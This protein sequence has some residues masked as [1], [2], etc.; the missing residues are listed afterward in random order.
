MEM[1]YQCVLFSQHKNETSWFPE[2][3][4]LF[5]TSLS[6][7]SCLEETENKI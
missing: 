4:R 2:A 3:I 7:S 6:C 5:K 1:N